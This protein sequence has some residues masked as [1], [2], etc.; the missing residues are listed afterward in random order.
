M[1]FDESDYPDPAEMM[2]SLHRQNF[3]LI[4]SVWPKFGTET[5]VS[6]E[7]EKAHLLLT[8]AAAAGEPGESKESESWADL[9]NPKAQKAYWADLE[10]N[11]FAAGLDGWWLDASEPEGDP[12]K[13]D[14]TFLGPGKPS[15]MPTRFLKL[16]RCMTGKGLPTRINVS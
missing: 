5:E 2:A 4:I 3:H 11:L 12:L 10:R 6:H 1:R 15:A 13:D 7:M 16:Q 8:S 14:Q 9:F